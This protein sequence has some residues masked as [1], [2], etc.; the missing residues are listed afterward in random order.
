MPI[1]QRIPTVSNLK[2]I[3]LLVNIFKEESKI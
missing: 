3:F 2:V 1:S